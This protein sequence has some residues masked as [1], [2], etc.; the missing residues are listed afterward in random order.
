MIRC[1]FPILLS[2]SNDNL[3]TVG[4]PASKSLQI[5]SLR[6]KNN[7]HIS[8]SLCIQQILQ[9]D[10]KNVGFSCSRRTDRQKTICQ[11]VLT[12]SENFSGI[13]IPKNHKWSVFSIC[14]PGWN[15][16]FNYALSQQCLTIHSPVSFLFFSGSNFLSSKII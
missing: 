8:F 14:R 1:D 9:T 7:D 5:I 16:V 12:Q 3:L 10:I 13:R 6:V 2:V 4:N 11:H 15:D